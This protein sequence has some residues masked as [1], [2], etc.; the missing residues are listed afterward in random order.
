[1]LEE[2]K[3]T[4]WRANMRLRDEG[5]VALTWGNASAFDRETRLVVIK[6]SGV[7]YGKMSPGDMVIS[8]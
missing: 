8:V 1:M 4:V 2:L 7:E 5:L 3:E 6:P